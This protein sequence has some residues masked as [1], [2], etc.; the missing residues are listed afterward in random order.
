MIRP[1]RPH[2]VPARPQDQEHEAA[3]AP[4][5]DLADLLYFPTGTRCFTSS[6]QFKTTSNRSGAVF[7]N[8]R[9][10]DQQTPVGRDIEYPGWKAPP[11][12]DRQA[13]ATGV[14][15]PIVVGNP[16]TSTAMTSPSPFSPAS[17]PVIQRS[18]VTAPDRRESP[19]G[20]NSSR[21][22]R[23]RARGHLYLRPAGTASDGTR[24]TA[25]L[26]KPVAA[27]RSPGEA[28]G[29]CPV[30]RNRATPAR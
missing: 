25:H 27:E 5:P 20:G 13:F 18:S 12:I 4:L 7:L 29:S 1:L 21:P 15:L 24:A 16:L 8:T 22:C 17:P 14:G 9:L 6:N 23:R 3:S 11:R 19:V 28:A 26:V 10:H 30:S 2:R